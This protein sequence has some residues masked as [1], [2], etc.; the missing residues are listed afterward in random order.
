MSSSDIGKTPWGDDGFLCWLARKIVNWKIF[1]HGLNN[2]D[3]QNLE[4]IFCEMI[5][6]GAEQATSIKCPKCDDGFA[7]V[8]PYFGEEIE[9]H[10]CDGLGKITADDHVQLT[11]RFDEMSG[12]YMASDHLNAERIRRLQEMARGQR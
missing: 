8:D 9:C 11:D 1:C 12:D 10:Y 7:G 6:F 5:R 4:A 3:F 2:K